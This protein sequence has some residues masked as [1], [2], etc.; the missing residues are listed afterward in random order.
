MNKYFLFNK[1]IKIS[2]N[3]L[4]KSDEIID[5]LMQDPT[6]DISGYIINDRIPIKI[7]INDIDTPIY[8]PVPIYKKIKLKIDK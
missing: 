2:N 3:V 5:K 8:I 1:I 4:L 6:T 7:Y